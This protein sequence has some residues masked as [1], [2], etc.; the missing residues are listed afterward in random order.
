MASAGFSHFV[1][2]SDVFFAVVIDFKQ[3]EMVFNAGLNA[4]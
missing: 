4:S 2:S 1:T 3:L